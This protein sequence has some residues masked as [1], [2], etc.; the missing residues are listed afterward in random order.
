[1]ESGDV[2]SSILGDNEVRYVLT[3]LEN[4]CISRQIQQLKDFLFSLN[5]EELNSFYS[6]CSF[7]VPDP[8]ASMSQ[9]IVEGDEAAISSSRTRRHDRRR[10]HELENSNMLFEHARFILFRAFCSRPFRYLIDYF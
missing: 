9:E 1:M 8:W 3:L 7:Y 10:I 6:T 5:S 2:A 4:V